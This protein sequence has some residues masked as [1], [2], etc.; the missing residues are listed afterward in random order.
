MD[1]NTERRGKPVYKN[2]WPIGSIVFRCDWTATS[3]KNP[4]HHHSFSK[5]SP[6]SY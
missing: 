1:L 6:T 2:N 4:V 3:Y 5:G